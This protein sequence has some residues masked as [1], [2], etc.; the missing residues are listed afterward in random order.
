M[1]QSYMKKQPILRLVLKMSLPMILSML[2]NSLYNIIDSYFVSGIS[3]K[4]M[5]ALS[6]VFPVQNLI[7]AVCIGFGIGMNAVI[8]FFLGAQKNDRAD[9]AATQGVILSFIHGILLT[10]ISIAIMPRFLSSFT[11]DTEIIDMG[12]Q[13]SNIVFSFSTFIA[14]DLALEKIFQSVGAMTVSMASMMTGCIA[15]IILDPILI[16]GFGS[17]PAMGIKG[18]AIATGIGHILTLAAYLL[19]YFFK[20]I[21]V[22]LHFG[23]FYWN[24]SM[25][26]K[27]Y[28]IGIPA[29]LNLALPSIL[30]SALN[31]I[32]S[33]FSDAYVLALGIYYKLQT[34]LYLTANGLI[35]G[36]RPL[37][38]Y[39]YGAGETK[40]V[41][42]IYSTTMILTLGIMF[43]GTVLCL[44]V[45]DKLM[46]IFMESEE[47][48][49]IG[50]TALRIISI[51]FIVSSV[52]VVSSGALEGLGMGVP[53]L[54]ISLCR[55]LVIIVP[56]AFIL[57]RSVGV[58]G[59]WH[60]FWVTEFISA[61]IS[62]LMFKLM[63]REERA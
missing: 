63:T 8:A 42:K 30:V 20:P 36:I 22:K 27:L 4:A 34:F 3:D 23:R 59:V 58:T 6:L 1:D 38:G 18:A 31:A 51:G 15:N 62:W 56:A 48:I 40:R 47:S 53:S 39:N 46:G 7:G 28:S 54:I 5:T 26:G 60:A 32:L 16:S 29:T 11:T 35:Q 43:V 2:V 61:A 45:P 24:W 49:E 41:K 13:Y 37:I 44:S 12:L 17:I 9:D 14:V 50:A 52:S 25:T 10:V 33:S 21:P 57:S 55:Y 19:F